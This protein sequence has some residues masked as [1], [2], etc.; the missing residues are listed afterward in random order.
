MAEYAK[1]DFNNLDDYCG[2]KT[3]TFKCINVNSIHKK[4]LYTVNI[5]LCE[6][7]VHYRLIITLILKL[8]LFCILLLVKKVYS[9]IISLVYRKV[10]SIGKQKNIVNKQYHILSYTQHAMQNK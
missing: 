3:M 1:F 6:D 8:D 7:A 5:F 9:T 2:Q 4:K 10:Y